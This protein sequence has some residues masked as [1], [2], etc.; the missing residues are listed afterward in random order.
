MILHINITHGDN[1]L[2]VRELHMLIIHSNVVSE[3]KQGDTERQVVVR[4]MIGERWPHL[5]KSVVLVKA[6]IHTGIMVLNIT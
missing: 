6:E 1:S 2:S 4:L 3:A 5:Q